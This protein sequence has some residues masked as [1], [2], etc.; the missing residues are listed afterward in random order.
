MAGCRPYRKRFSAYLDGELPLKKR[1]AVA[2]HL[3]VC[4]ACRR[5]LEDIEKL[6]PALMRPGVFPPSADL[7]ARIM[8]EAR[9]RQA[10]GSSA[11]RVRF[12]P[13]FIPSWSWWLKTG[14]A[15]AMVVLLL[16]FG[17]WMSEKEWLP[18]GP[19][20]CGHEHRRRRPWNGSRRRRP[21]RFVRLSGHCP[22][23]C[24]AAGQPSR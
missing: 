5:E 22:G 19:P 9:Q 14:G 11:A 6:G 12:K 17:Q 18:G 4:A 15:A 1:A 20:D 13:V 23:V 24:S 10:T 16:Y 21:S 7:S 8:A 2:E 3:A